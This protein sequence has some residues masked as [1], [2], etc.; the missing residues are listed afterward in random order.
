MRETGDPAAFHNLNAAWHLAV[1]RASHN[2]LLI[3]VAEALGPHLHDPRVE[4]FASEDIRRSVLQAHGRV[5]E[6]IAARDSDA[7]RR[8]MARH[9]GAYRARIEAVGP[10]TVTLP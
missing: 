6:A 2:L 5:Q 4:D 1:A 8:R 10:R 3:A 7:A 9:V